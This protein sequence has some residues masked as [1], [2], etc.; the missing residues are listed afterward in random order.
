M[1]SRINQQRASEKTDYDLRLTKDLDV[2]KIQDLTEAV[3]WGRRGDDKWRE[4]LSKSAVVCSLWHGDRLVGFGR[5]VEDGVMCMLYDIAVHPELQ[6]QGLGSRIMQAL[7]DRVKDRNYV[8]IG[9]FAWD[10]NPANI[11]FYE[12]FE[13]V[14]SHGMELTKYMRTEG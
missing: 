1:M 2:V 14:P 13:F 11:P 3:S 9:L 12:K 5:V 4:T 8:S 7:I 6:N 10:K